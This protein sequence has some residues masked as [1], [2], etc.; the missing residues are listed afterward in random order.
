MYTTS[1]F[2]RTEYRLI[3]TLIVMRTLKAD[4]FL[5]KNINLSGSQ[6][7]EMDRTR[8]RSDAVFKYRLTRARDVNA[9]EATSSAKICECDH[10]EVFETSEPLDTAGIPG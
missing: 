10:A 1:C 3:V 2:R 9:S 4:L 5:K 7:A 8:F 6:F